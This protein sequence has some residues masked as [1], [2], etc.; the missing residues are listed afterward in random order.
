MNNKIK[1]I[2]LA[3]IST[4]TLAACNGG[5]SSNSTQ[6]STTPIS[7]A[8]VEADVVNGKIYEFRE[9][10]KNKL[11]QVNLTLDV[12]PHGSFKFR[13]LDKIKNKLV[14]HYFSNLNTFNAAKPTLDKSYSN[15]N[16][17]IKSLKD[18]TIQSNLGFDIGF[19]PSIG[20]PITSSGSTLEYK[21]TEQPYCY[22]AQTQINNSIGNYGFQSVSDFT[23]TN[24]S[25]SNASLLNEKN[26][27]SGSY[28]LFSGSNALAYSNN[29]QGSSSNGSFQFSNVVLTNIGFTVNSLSDFGISML[30]QNPSTFIQNCGSSTVQTMPMGWMVTLGMQLQAGDSS[31]TTS[32][33]DTLKAKYSTMVSM[34]NQ[35]SDTNTS[36]TS[37]FSINFSAVVSSDYTF[38]G[39][40]TITNNSITYTIAAGTALSKVLSDI[41]TNTNV[42]NAC[43]NTTGQG[44][45]VTTSCVTA[46]T[47]YDNL[48]NQ[49]LSEIPGDIS[50]YGLPTSLEFVDAFPQGINLA[51]LSQTTATYKP[52]AQQPQIINSLTGQAKTNLQLVSDP[53]APSSSNLGNYIQLI[54]QLNQLSVSAKLYYD[55]IDNINPMTNLPNSSQQLLNA[56]NMSVDTA[57]ANLAQAYALDAQELTS[58]ISN[59]LNDSTQCSSLPTL[60]IND[61]Y[62]FY[63]GSNIYNSLIKTST[64]NISLS[65]RAINALLLQYNETYS[66][67]ANLGNPGNVWSATD[68]YYVGSATPSVSNSVPMAFIYLDPQNIF[69]SPGGILGVALAGL[70]MANPFCQSQSGTTCTYEQNGSSVLQSGPLASSTQYS[71]ATLPET[72]FYYFLRDQNAGFAGLIDN[73]INPAVQLNNYFM[74]AQKYV[75]GI[76]TRDFPNDSGEYFQPKYTGQL[77]VPNT[78]PTSSSTNPVYISS[79]GNGSSKF[80]ISSYGAGTNSLSVGIPYNV[81]GVFGPIGQNYN[82]YG[83]LLKGPETQFTETVSGLDPNWVLG[84]PSLTMSIQQSNGSGCYSYEGAYKDYN[85]CDGSGLYPYNDS[86]FTT[87][88]RWGALATTINSTENTMT[89]TQIPNFFN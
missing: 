40:Y 85:G 33:S 61:A 65:N 2:S 25:S 27:I 36:K 49:A 31:Q 56:Q 17:T 3:V 21:G 46:V 12:F 53:Y 79:A 47:N 81:N 63:T 30:A 24:A 64:S 50:K 82:L 26:N 42:E 48:A 6:G 59:C 60:P 66:E 18:S 32:I 77:I 7:G 34:T 88:T 67:Y 15:A 52:L 35:L 16:K 78:Y 13:H 29:Y 37:S 1:L 89:F 11:G 4:F 83:W 75:S 44:N 70:S 23:A 58:I 39:G 68:N 74:M 54:W 71:S 5:N 8:H 86:D 72:P 14:T 62:D 55:I 9:Y 38:Q 80:S 87:A 19:N 51:G 22:N 20:Q 45:L 43:T 10:R 28:G 41:Q 84:V 73:S 69:G 76:Q 57:F